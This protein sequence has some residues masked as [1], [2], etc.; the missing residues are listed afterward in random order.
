VPPAKDRRVPP[1]LVRVVA[2]GLRARPEDR[3]PS[4]NAVV[5]AL[6]R[7]RR[8][9]GRIVA[10]FAIAGVALAA[11]ALALVLRPSPAAPPPADTDIVLP[12]PRP[13]CGCP[14]STCD[15]TCVSVCRANHY[16]VGEPIPGVSLP[17]RQE[18]LLGVSGDGNTI[19][20][21]A[22]KGC[23][24][25][26]LWI[27]H[28]RGASY[29]SIDITA[30]LD[31]QHASMFEGCCTLAASGRALVMAR[32][33]RRGFVR[34]R[35]DGDTPLPYDSTDEL[36][37]VVPAVPAHIEAQFPALS[38][39][40]LT[41]YYRVF[42]R[43]LGDPSDLGPLEGVY[44]AHRRD[45]NSPLD[46]GTLLPRRARFYD[47]VTGISSD[48]LSLFMSAEYRTHVLVRPSVDKPFSDPDLGML[49]ALLP[50]WRAMP[51]ADC[52]RIAATVSPGGCGNEDIVFLEAVP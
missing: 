28:R 42:D 46:P 32:P 4:M 44:A 1:W 7:G 27:A 22:N 47:V 26:H 19:A 13:G 3:W 21:L 34:V 37:A 29:E 31:L 8:R 52:R 51:T 18:A 36:G 12:D 30:K 5:D 17:G 41:L 33:D 43:S 48:G 14:M 2:R 25:D 45:P 35:L 11:V 38:A 6:V 49:P 20:Y 23:R 10:A 9:R 39:D 24:I 16:V 40:E 50:G 15:T